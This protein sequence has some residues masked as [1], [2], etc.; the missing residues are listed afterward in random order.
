MEYTTPN[1]MQGPLGLQE[2]QK[3]RKLRF[4]NPSTEPPWIEIQFASL[5]QSVK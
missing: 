3:Q 4:Q 2:P 5:I 1:R